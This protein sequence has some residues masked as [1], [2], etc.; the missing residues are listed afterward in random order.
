MSLISRKTCLSFSL[1]VGQQLVKKPGVRKVHV[2]AGGGCRGERLRQWS[3]AKTIES[4][5]GVRKKEPLCCLSV[6]Y[7]QTCSNDAV[8]I[9]DSIVQEIVLV[10]E[11]TLKYNISLGVPSLI[12]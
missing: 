8:S 9:T 3:K 10:L 5:R 6:F 11:F 2:W 1:I 12:S 4:Q 7:S